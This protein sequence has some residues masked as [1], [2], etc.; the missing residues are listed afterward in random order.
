M[1]GLGHSWN[2]YL[3]L[4]ASVL[5]GSTSYA[6]CSAT[7][8]SALGHTETGS[9]QGILDVLSS[10]KE[11]LPTPNPPLVLISWSSLLPLATLPHV[12]FTG[13]LS[14]R[15]L[16]LFLRFGLRNSWQHL[17]PGQ[18]SQ[19]LRDNLGKLK[20]SLLLPNVTGH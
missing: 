13:Q 7:G 8:T 10:M 12:S 9:V 4:P 3:N 20:P 17:G 19:N 14:N 1:R 5:C 18:T 16:G 6:S 15:S 2:L 11:G